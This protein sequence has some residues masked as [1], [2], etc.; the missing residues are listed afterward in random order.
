M[1]EYSRTTTI[2][3]VLGRR[4]SFESLPST[5]T[6]RALTSKSM[7]A[8]LTLEK[9]VACTC[10]VSPHIWETS[11]T[12]AFDLHQFDDS[13]IE[14]VYWIGIDQPAKGTIFPAQRHIMSTSENKTQ[15]GHGV[16]R[17]YK[18]DHHIHNEPVCHA[19]V[20][21]AHDL[22]R[23]FKARIERCSSYAPDS[24]EKKK[25]LL[26]LINCTPDLL[27]AANSHGAPRVTTPEQQPTYQ[28]M[29]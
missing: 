24:S 23:I 20:H 21:T 15:P 1:S 6:H 4:E 12:D 2:G 17:V 10:S 18:A 13:I 8:Y 5:A 11:K 25:Q 9:A 3:C 22:L 26:S 7:I 16:R 29:L 19:L 28:W 27:G 14:S